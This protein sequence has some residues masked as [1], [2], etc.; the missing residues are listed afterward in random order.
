MEQI[1]GEFSIMVERTRMWVQVS[2]VTE[3]RRDPEGPQKKTAASSD[4]EQPAEVVWG[5]SGCHLVDSWRS[6]SG[7]VPLGQTP[8][9]LEGSLSLSQL[10]WIPWRIPPE[11]AGGNG[12]S[13]RVGIWL[14]LLSSEKWYEESD[15]LVSSTFYCKR[16]YIS[17]KRF[18]SS[19]R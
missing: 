4:Q 2:E 16:G 7:L 8:D 17:A 3:E 1:Y 18:C 13:K 19:F 12:L 10:A 9:M 15:T 11:H 14:D 6:D 5:S